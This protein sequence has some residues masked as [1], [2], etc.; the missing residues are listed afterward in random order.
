MI[1]TTERVLA[2]RQIDV[3]KN[4]LKSSSVDYCLS[5]TP[6]SLNIQ[7]KKRFL[8][9][10]SPKLVQN[11][12]LNETSASPI[13]PNSFRSQNFSVG[14]SFITSNPTCEP[15][16]TSEGNLKNLEDLVQ[17]LKEQ[18]IKLEESNTEKDKIIS[19]LESKVQD[20][21]LDTVVFLLVGTGV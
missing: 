6:Y 15:C 5:E 9:D 10:N 4:A 17:N 20:A 21:L 7:L 3:I 11:H 16:K 2:E 14:D 13:F 1:D 19:Q 8:K 12:F 18:N